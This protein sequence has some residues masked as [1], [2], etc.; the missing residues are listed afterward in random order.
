MDR[1]SKIGDGGSSIEDEGSSMKDWGSRIEVWGSRI[2]VRGSRFE[3]RGSGRP[4]NFAR[5]LIRSFS[6]T[7]KTIAIDK[8]LDTMLLF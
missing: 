7:Q 4:K 5:I 2:E 3:V 1:G 6:L 8:G